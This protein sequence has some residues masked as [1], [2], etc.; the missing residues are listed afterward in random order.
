MLSNNEI[1]IG[2]RRD[3]FL[4]ID[5]ETFHSREAARTYVWLAEPESKPEYEAGSG[6]E[7]Q[8]EVLQPLKVD[9]KHT[10][11]TLFARL[12][13]RDLQGE[14]RRTPY[15]YTSEL[16]RLHA[17]PDANWEGDGI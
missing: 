12:V 1:P 8:P 3:V 13:Q 11:P 2:F 17:A 6:T 7:A 5:K 15:R 4:Y 14:A 16:S 10:T 9:I